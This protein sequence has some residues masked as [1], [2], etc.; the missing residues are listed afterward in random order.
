MVQNTYR[1]EE[2]MPS[3]DIYLVGA[4]AQTCAH[5][6][7]TLWIYCVNNR[8]S[9]SSTEDDVLKE[10]DVRTQTQKLVVALTEIQQSLPDDG[11][12][13]LLAEINA[14]IGAGRHGR[15]L[16]IHGALSKEP[17]TDQLRLHHHWKMKGEK[18]VF[19]WFNE[20]LAPG[21]LEQAIG[22]ADELLGMVHELFALG[23]A[24]WE[25]VPDGGSAA[26]PEGNIP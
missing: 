15:N 19:E 10:L 12:Q 2:H 26:A 17:G 22:S 21:A 25:G 14:R 1:V 24:R 18:R 20:P 23:K 9:S 4:F 3:H 8:L 6:E 11:E 5:I 16:I 7:H 13:R